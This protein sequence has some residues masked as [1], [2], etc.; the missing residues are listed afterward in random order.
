MERGVA[1]DVAESG[2]ISELAEELA[3]SRLEST[4]YSFNALR[5]STFHIDDLRSGLDSAINMF[6]ARKIPWTDPCGNEYRIAGT[7]QLFGSPQSVQVSLD[8]VACALSLLFAS[9]LETPLENSP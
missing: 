5:N 8:H 7:A 4:M 6:D 3:L 9:I 2:T 1:M